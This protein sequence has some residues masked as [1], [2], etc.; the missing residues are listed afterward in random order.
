MELE[1]QRIPVIL[2]VQEN[3]HPK[4]GTKQTAEQGSSGRSQDRAE[5]RKFLATT[6]YTKA[7]LESYL[8][9]LFGS[10][11]LFNK[12]LK[13]SINQELN[14]VIVKVID[15]STDE[16]IKEIPS[17]ELQR[18]QAKINEAIG[19]LFDEKI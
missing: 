2:P 11:L 14:Q 12:K 17:A 5:S 13:F 16:V 19:L 3:Q 4:R 15:G 6:S 7:E 9:K 8:N 10:N 1:I 18:L